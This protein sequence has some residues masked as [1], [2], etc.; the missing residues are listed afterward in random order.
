MQEPKRQHLDAAYRLLHYLKEAPGQGLL[1]S[2]ENKLKLIGYCDA[3]WARCPITRRSVTGYCIFLSN[4]L[5]SW[6][7]KK[8]VT[9]ARS[10]AKAEYRS[11]AAATCELT[12][13]RYLL[14]DLRVA[15]SEPAKLFCG[16]SSGLIHC[17]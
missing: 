11:M 6:K 16:Q 17:S 1:F 10:S 13:L 2:A 14:Q 12:W 5:V 3:D 7:S 8:Q 9:I 15:H 4:A